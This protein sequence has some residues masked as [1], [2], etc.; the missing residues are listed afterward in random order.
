MSNINKENK[1]EKWKEKT[2]KRLNREILLNRTRD[3]LFK[4]ICSNTFI[5]ELEKMLSL[6][7]KTNCNGR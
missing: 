3:L 7:E 5:P 4:P 1:E 6:Y 2:L